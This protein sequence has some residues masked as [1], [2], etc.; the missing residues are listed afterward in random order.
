[1]YVHTIW[2]PTVLELKWR[3]TWRQR[4]SELGHAIGV[5]DRVNLE[6]HLGGGGRASFE[7]I[8]EAVI[9]R[10]W[11]CTWRCRSNEFGDALKSGD[12]ASLEIHWRL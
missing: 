5:L 11:K 6:M 1:M 2:L 9:E 10:L 7:M 3:S 4:L 8:L 12:R